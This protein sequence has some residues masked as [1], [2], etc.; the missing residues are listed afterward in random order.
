MQSKK[1]LNFFSLFSSLSL[2]DFVI[3][4]KHS[5]TFEWLAGIL[6][7]PFDVAKQMLAEF[8]RQNSDS[9]YCTYFLGGF[10]SAKAETNL[11]DHVFVLVRQEELEIRRKEFVEISCQ[12]VYSVG[13]Q[14]PVILDSIWAEESVKFQDLLFDEKSPQT[15][16]YLSNRWSAISNISLKRSEKRSLR[17]AYLSPKKGTPETKWA[18]SFSKLSETSA[19]DSVA[20]AKRKIGFAVEEKPKKKA[21]TLDSAKKAGKERISGKKKNTPFQLATVPS[22]EEE[23]GATIPAPKGSLNAFFGAPQKKGKQPKAEEEKN[24]SGEG[25]KKEF[26]SAPKK[27]SSTGSLKTVSPKKKPSSATPEK[28][29]KKRKEEKKEDSEDEIFFGESDSD[30]GE[31]ELASEE[32]ADFGEIEE[33]KSPKKKR[34]PKKKRDEGLT[35]IDENEDWVQHLE[36]PAKSEIRRKMKTEVE[37]VDANG[38]TVVTEVWVDDPSWKAEEKKEERKKKKPEALDEEEEEVKPKKK[39]RASKKKKK[40]ADEEEEEEK[41]PTSAPK[42]PVGI[43]GFFSKAP[44]KK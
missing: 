2:Q 42:K 41:E 21:A 28:R 38:Y 24:E 32:A 19:N 40:S 33:E 35:K 4:Q 5:I 20:A 18:D 34:T 23:E 10:V 11:L 1:E 13:P 22:D 14:R 25:K 43:L 16:D 39:A 36:K 9:V 7:V 8:K 44:P 12:H 30:F 17:P 26:F 6:A 15:I 29:L 37:S 31:N 27:P 3:E